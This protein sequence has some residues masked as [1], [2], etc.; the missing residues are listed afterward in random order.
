MGHKHDT[1]Y[2]TGADRLGIA[3]AIACTIHC[4][5][6]PALFIIR[7]SFAATINGHLPAGFPAWWPLLDYLFLAISFYAVYHASTHAADKG[8]KWLLWS[9]WL[10]LALA[11]FF[12][13]HVRWLAYVASAGLVGTHITNIKKHRRKIRTVNEVEASASPL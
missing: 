6:I 1:D 2:T 11:V 7:Y 9:F 10:C 3:S 4:L 13:E 8:V 12:E 5:V